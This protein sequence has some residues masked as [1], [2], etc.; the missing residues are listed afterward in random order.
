MKKTLVRAL[1]GTTAVAAI[2]LG[3]FLYAAAHRTTPQPSPE[4]TPL[5]PAST[6]PRPD[7]YV[8]ARKDLAEE[9]QRRF[10]DRKDHDFGYDRV[11]RSDARVHMGPVANRSQSEEEDEKDGETFKKHA[12]SDG[13]VGVDGKW[14]TEHYREVF[15][16]ENSTERETLAKLAD[17]PQTVIYTAGVFDAKGEPNRVNGPAYLSYIGEMAPTLNGEKQEESAR[18]RAWLKDAAKRL[19][20]T[21][22]IVSNG[23]LITG[24]KV[25]ADGKDCIKCYNDGDQAYDSGGKPK[26]MA[27]GDAIGLILIASKTAA[28]VPSG[29]R[30]GVAQLGRALALGA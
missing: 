19:L 10:H 9:L 7:L 5:T 16:A 13:W 25:V 26:R 11:V 12:S 1:A 8:Q 4:T 20:T 24:H 17:G 3:T 28:K 29:R 22:H 2:G 23:W 30:R 27:V 14:H 15:A 21:D 18:A 6:K